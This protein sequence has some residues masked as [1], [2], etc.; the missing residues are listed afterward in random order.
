M[1]SNAKIKKTKKTDNAYGR[2]RATECERWT[3]YRDE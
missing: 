3:S 2:G 1:M